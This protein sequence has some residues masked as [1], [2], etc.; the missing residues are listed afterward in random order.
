MFGPSPHSAWK[1]EDVD[2]MIG[3]LWGEKD[4]AKRIAGYKAV[5]RYIAEQ[6]Y[7][8]PLLQ[9]KQPV[10]YRK[11]PAVHA[12]HRRLHPAAERQ[13]GLTLRV[14]RMVSRRRFLRASGAAL[15]APVVSS[16]T[17]AAPA[18]AAD[19]VLT[20]A[21]NTT[22]PGWDPTSSAHAANP[23]VQSIYKSVFDSYV[24]QNPDLSFKPGILTRWEWNKDK[25]RIRL[26]L[27]ED[28]YWHDGTPV[29]PEDLIWSLERAGDPK[30][31][32]PMQFV[33]GKIG[34]FRADGLYR[35][36]GC[37]RIRAGPAQV[38]GVP[39]RIHPSE[40]SLHR[41]QRGE[42]GCTADWQRP[43]HGGEIR[44]Q[45]LCP[46]QGLPEVLGTEA[47]VRRPGSSVASSRALANSAAA[48]T[49]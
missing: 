22:L 23:V 49:R 33:W 47:G 25:T 17:S 11:R 12:A 44:A 24:D 1:T 2:K 3:P 36:G 5:D 15:A 6:G 29:T 41:S 45:R 8:L 31:S 39:D 20:I 35:H 10:V 27:R 16:L 43:I 38:D 46:S 7:V 48:G 37:E 4:E 19:S 13:A 18:R 26:T 9:Y 30:G 34:G 21:Y 32:N 14:V 40:E 42:L 28:A